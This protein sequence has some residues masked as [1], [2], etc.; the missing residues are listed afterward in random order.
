MRLTLAMFVVA[1]CFPGFGSAPAW[2][3]DSIAL[4]KVPA[5]V[6]LAAQKAVPGIKIME[7]MKG[8]EEG[9][10]IY[11]IV[12]ENAKGLDV[13]VEVTADGHVQAISVEMSLQD[14][15]K[16]VMTALRTKVKGFK[17]TDVMAVYDASNKLMEYSFEGKDAKGKDIEVAVSADGSIVEVDDDPA[18]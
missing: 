13:E 8:M 4:S 9:V 12:G 14:V 5:P 15:P 18:N 6:K 7:A 11:T 3:D 10:V 16:V 17:P 2:A 1:I